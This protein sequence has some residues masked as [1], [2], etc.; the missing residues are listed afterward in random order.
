MSLGGQRSES[1]DS[2]DSLVDQGE[3]GA[4]PNP[5]R[6]VGETATSGEFGGL[7]D[8]TRKASRDTAAFAAGSS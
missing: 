2:S 6:P 4:K 3:T 7:R 8:H 5:F 1:V